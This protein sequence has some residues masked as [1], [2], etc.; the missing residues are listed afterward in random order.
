MK[1]GCPFGIGGIWEPWRREDQGP[2]ESC[3]II[4]TEA[5]ELVR[6]INNRMPVIVA[7]GDYDRWLDPEF[8]DLAELGRMMQPFPAEGMTVGP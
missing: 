1:N 4:T 2:I 3:A 8:F 7:E 5:N 6:P